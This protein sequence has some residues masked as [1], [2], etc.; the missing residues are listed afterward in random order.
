MCHNS[1]SNLLPPPFPPHLLCHGYPFYSLHICC[2]YCNYVLL[3]SNHKVLGAFQALEKK[4]KKAQF[5]GYC[6]RVLAGLS[7]C[8][9]CVKYAHKH[10]A[11]LIYSCLCFSK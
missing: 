3:G 7:Q 11:Y 10:V 1:V 4:K 6:N 2:C 5:L 8:T 9:L